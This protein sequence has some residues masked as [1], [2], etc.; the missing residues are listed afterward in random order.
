MLHFPF[1]FVCI[2]FCLL[3]SSF[4]SF[5]SLYYPT[6]FFGFRSFLFFT[7][8]S[9]CCSCF[10]SCFQHSKKKARK[11]KTRERKKRRRRRRRRNKRERERTKES[12]KGLGE[13]FL[14]LS[15]LA[16]LWPNSCH[17]TRLKTLK[18]KDCLVISCWFLGGFLCW[19]CSLQKTT[20]R[21]K[22]TK[23]LL[24]VSLNHNKSIS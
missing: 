13:S 10:P 7:F 9:S 3:S 14:S 21:P 22:K 8:V 15:L 17:E 20:K 2:H 24:I 1:Q 5:H 6:S 4:S 12:M 11:E 19:G 16:S 23:N 18:N